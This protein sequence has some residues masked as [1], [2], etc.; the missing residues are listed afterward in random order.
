MATLHNIPASR[1]FF[2]S[3]SPF[4]LPC[5]TLQIVFI[6]YLKSIDLKMSHTQNSPQIDFYTIFVCLPKQRIYK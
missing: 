3:P 4:P 6:N 5:P 2:F 1:E